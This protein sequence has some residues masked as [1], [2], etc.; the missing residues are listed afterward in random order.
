LPMPAHCRYGR[1]P[2]NASFTRIAL[3]GVWPAGV[4]AD[5]G[6]MPPASSHFS[7]FATAR[8]S[9]T[10]CSISPMPRFLIRARKIDDGCTVA[11]T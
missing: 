5:G 11:V 7:F 4:L 2:D 8:R 10:N 1:A 9:S 6:G 3:S